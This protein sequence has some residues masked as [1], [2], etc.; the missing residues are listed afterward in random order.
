MKTQMKPA[1]MG[2]TTNSRPV[3]RG[4]RKTAAS[5]FSPATFEYAGGDDGLDKSPRPAN[6]PC[7]RAISER[8][9]WFHHLPLV[10]VIAM[11][12]AMTVHA[13]DPFTPPNFPLPKFKDAKFNV[14]DFGATGNGLTNDTPA[15]N[16]AI[17]K[18]NASGG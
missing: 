3:F 16:K 15:I 8:R 14:R 7:A 18:C 6:E 12:L 4:L 5:N 1:A 11:S 13:A 10:T 2:G 9:I 17:E